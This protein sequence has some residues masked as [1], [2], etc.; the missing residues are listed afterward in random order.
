MGGDVTDKTQIVTKMK[1]ELFG[2]MAPDFLAKFLIEGE[3]H[4]ERSHDFLEEQEVLRSGFH[5][6]RMPP[7]ESEMPKIILLDMRPE[8]DFRKFRI[9]NAIS[10]PAVNI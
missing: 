10:F 2:R 5:P 4:T 9:R 7:S 8:S 6:A 1:G 3:L